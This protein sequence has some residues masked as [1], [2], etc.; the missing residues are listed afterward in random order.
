MS[1]DFVEA[2]VDSDIG[3]FENRVEEIISEYFTG[4]PFGNG[5]DVVQLTDHTPYSYI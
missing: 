4:E 2:S 5:D 1:F 3:S